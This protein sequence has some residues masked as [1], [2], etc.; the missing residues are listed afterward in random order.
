MDAATLQYYNENA[1]EVAG[2]YESV[3]GGVASFFPFV[4]KRGECALD[5]GAGT[6]R[7][8]AVLCELGMDVR[9]VEPSAALRQRARE[10]HPELAGRLS[11]GALP[12][13]LPP[14]VLTDTYDGIVLS[15]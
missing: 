6:G 2:R 11:D 8:A 5:L 9:A 10:L 1:G 4:F 3:T 7:D 15:G 12:N 14:A 13:A